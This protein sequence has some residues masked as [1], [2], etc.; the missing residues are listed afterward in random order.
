MEANGYEARRW[1]GK[2]IRDK[3]YMDVTRCNF[4]SLVYQ[5]WHF[6]SIQIIPVTLNGPLYE[7]AAA[8]PWGDMLA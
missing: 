4:M 6:L 2:V 7:L 1:Y 8:P 3:W 5:V